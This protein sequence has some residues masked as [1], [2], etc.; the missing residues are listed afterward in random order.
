MNKLLP[1]IIFSNKIQI[2]LTILLAKS[3]YRII[4]R[5]ITDN[6]INQNLFEFIENNN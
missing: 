3:K 1:E 4:L 2:I 5:Q 6:I